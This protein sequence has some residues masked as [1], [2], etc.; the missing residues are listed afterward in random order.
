MRKLFLGF[1]MVTFAAL[2][3][4]CSDDATRP[5]SVPLGGADLNASAPMCG[6]GRTPGLL[7][8]YY[9]I[10]WPWDLTTGAAL[11]K[12]DTRTGQGTRLCTFILPNDPEYPGELV[13]WSPFGLTF[14]T[15]GT[16][17]TIVDF[18][19]FTGAVPWSRLV[20]IDPRTGQMT[21]IGEHY[22]TSF[23]GPEM[24]CH[25]NIYA[26]GFTV[27]D[28]AGGP[29]YIYGDS[30][31]YRINKNTGVATRIGDT[32]R[33]DWM[34]L[35]FDTQ[36]RLWATTK[37]KLWIL[38]TRTGAAT[39]MFDIVGV[40]KE[41]IPGCCSQDWPYMEVMSIAFDSA[42]RLWATAMRGFS[43]CTEVNAPMLEIDI[44][45]G[46]ATLVGYTNQVYNHGGDYLKKA[47]V[48][49]EPRK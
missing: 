30:Y 39:F 24:D 23:A 41:S 45:T 2:V 19:D 36:G 31:L 5:T 11:L 12:I 14:D 33:T 49:P 43:S 18:L 21:F 29:P 46:H 7:P 15:D 20:R 32:G 8:G 16:M 34:D 37:N 38:N 22:N 47:A 25:G 1:C 40:P 13:M 4:G 48:T 6:E 28:P 9:S 17:Y 44:H 27:G 26:T 3:F 10:F 35:A 42:N